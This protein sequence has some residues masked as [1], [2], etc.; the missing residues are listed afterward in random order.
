[1]KNASKSEKVVFCVMSTI[2]VVLMIVFRGTME[3]YLEMMLYAVTKFSYDIGAVWSTVIL[4]AMSVAII[5][6]AALADYKLRQMEKSDEEDCMED[7]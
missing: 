5:G 4:I 1:M 2:V 7:R 6:L 3:K